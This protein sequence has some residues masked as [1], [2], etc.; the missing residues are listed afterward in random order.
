MKDHKQLDT[1]TV[2]VVGE[3]FFFRKEQVYGVQV[4]PIQSYSDHV[5][6]IFL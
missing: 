5:L 4:K 3:I 2:G 1:E 6:I